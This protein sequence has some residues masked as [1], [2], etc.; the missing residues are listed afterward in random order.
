MVTP[1]SGA[2]GTGP[3]GEP[4]GVVNTLDYDFWRSQFGNTSAPPGSG[5]RAFAAP[6]PGTCAVVLG[7]LPAVLGVRRSSRRSR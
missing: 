4:D 6:E 2:D 3:A 1:G 7:F 5:A